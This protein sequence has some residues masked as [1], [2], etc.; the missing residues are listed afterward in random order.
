L[1]LF[2]S[3][4]IACGDMRRLYKNFFPIREAIACR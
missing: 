2:A 1:A 4:S 3:E